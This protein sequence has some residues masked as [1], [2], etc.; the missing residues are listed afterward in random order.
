MEL[1]VFKPSFRIPPT[2]RQ[3]TLLANFLKPDI[4]EQA[5]HKRL[6][7]P[8]RVCRKRPAITMQ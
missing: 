7:E 5:C 4:A 3:T 2:S 8:L 1:K 6:I